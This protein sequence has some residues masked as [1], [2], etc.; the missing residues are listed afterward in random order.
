LKASLAV[1]VLLTVVVAGCGSE[2]PDPSRTVVATLGEEPVYLSGLQT[3]F[4]ANLLDEHEASPAEDRDRVKSRLF[5]TFLDERLLAD[6]A[7]GRGLEVSAI[8]IEA[9]LEFMA[10][11]GDEP[12]D[13]SADE[14]RREAVRR[15]LLLQK[16]QERILSDQAPPNHDEVRSWIAD[17]PDRFEVESRVRLRSLRF[18]DLASAEQVHRNLRRG[19]ITFDEA[20][21]AH[22]SS[23]DQGTPVEVGLSSMIE[24]QRAALDGLRPG[25]VSNP[26]AT[27]GGFY[28]FQIIEWIEKPARSDEARRREAKEALERD[29]GAAAHRKELVRLREKAGIRIKN[30]A[31]PFTY[32][33]EDSAP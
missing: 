22:G 27:S 13:D 11:V 23:P 24:E 18:E 32:L 30:G 26:V 4:S 12:V 21:I 3:Y 25:Q 7:R 29:R 8:E 9:W 14:R 1:V 33:P 2:P 31:L 15:M 16:L 17:H 28:L 19:R 5:D 6:E 20:V 10:D